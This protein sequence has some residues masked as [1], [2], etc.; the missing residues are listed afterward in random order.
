MLA[1]EVM[2]KVAELIFNKLTLFIV[3][4]VN[5]NKIQETDCPRHILKAAKLL[6]YLVI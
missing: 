5:V 2:V 3:I 4:I 1:K 6:S